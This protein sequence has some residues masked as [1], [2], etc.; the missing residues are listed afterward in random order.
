MRGNYKVLVAQYGTEVGAVHTTVVAGMLAYH[1]SSAVGKDAVACDALVVAHR[2]AGH[3]PGMIVVARAEER[4][5]DLEFHPHTTQDVHV[6]LEMHLSCLR[7]GT[8]LGLGQ[9]SQWENQF[10]QMH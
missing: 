6:E 4:N 3:I 8:W 5:A 7:E 9:Q 2:K 10:F 1:S